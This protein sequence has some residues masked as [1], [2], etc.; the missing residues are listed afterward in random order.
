MMFASFWTTVSPWLATA[1][2][3]AVCILLFSLS[4]AIHEF[5][6]FL[7]ARK[8]GYR[9]E[10]FSIGFGPA[11]WKKTVGGVEYRISAI[12]FGGYV[13]IPDVDPEGTKKLEGGNGE[14][15]T[16]NGEQGTGKVV[17]PPWKDLV[18][19][20]AGPMMNVVLAVAIAILL[21]LVPS[22]K[23]GVA[24]T[25]IGGVIPGT[26]AEAAGLQEGDE[27]VSI[28]GNPVRDW[29]GVR[30]EIQFIDGQEAPFVVMRDGERIVIPVKPEILEGGVALIGAYSEGGDGAGCAMWMPDRS[31]VKQILWDAGAVFRALR[32]LVTPKEMKRTGKALGGPVL[33]A[34]ST[35]KT[36]RSDTWDGLGFLRFVNTNLAVMNLLPIP[37]LDGGLILFSL[38]AIV[39]RRRVPDKIIAPLSTVFMYLLLGLMLLLVW[40]DIDRIVKL[41]PDGSGKT[42]EEV[43]E[44]DPEQTQSQEGQSAA[45]QPADGQME[46]KNAGE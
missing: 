15:G 14:Q 40:R 32:G 27:I 18:V 4:I 33:I 6:H 11:L 25:R 35:Y 1:G 13:S 23:F 34:R 2:Y 29:T 9:V 8:L 20:L 39:F 44:P 36:I 28:A 22:A 10:R 21:S 42:Q 45:E 41:S 16:G 17:M 46:E 37:V 43:Q 12:P 7:A 3:V 38:I 31:P 26:Q 5:G 30:T 19:A 24:S